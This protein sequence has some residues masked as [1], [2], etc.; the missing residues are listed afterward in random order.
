MKNSETEKE[1]AGL[2]KD[3][4]EHYQEDYI[5]GAWE[6]FVHYRRRKKRILI[7]QVT[8]GIAACLMIGWIGIGYFNQESN[9]KSTVTEVKESNVFIEKNKYPEAQLKEENRRKVIA[10]QR[11]AIQKKFNSGFKDSPEVLSGSAKKTSHSIGNDQKDTISAEKSIVTQPT[12]ENKKISKEFKASEKRITTDPVNRNLADNVQI[13]EKKKIRFG[14]NFSP[15]VNSTQ[16]GS[17]F[18]YSGGLSTDINLF[19]DVYLSTGLQIEHQSVMHDNNAPSVSNGNTF[20]ASVSRTKADLV[21]LDLPVN[22]TWKFYSDKSK[23]FYVSGGISSLAYL[24]EKYDKI[25]S[26]RQLTEVRSTSD[27]LAMENGLPGLTYRIENVEISNRQT[28]HSFNAVDWAGRVNIIFGIEQRLSPKLYL[29]LEPYMK[30]PVSGLATEK[31][32][33]S[34]GGVS[35]KISF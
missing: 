17:A 14:I 32:R 18:N 10:D 33:F 21:N 31:L 15:G 19:A 22:L 11:N 35:C 23:S 26:F 30:I 29:H 27:H 16:A 9:F 4:L 25:T 7:L 6:N 12:N 13:S 5:P 20:G 3:T 8:S 28:E 2:I 1:I 24:S 34:T